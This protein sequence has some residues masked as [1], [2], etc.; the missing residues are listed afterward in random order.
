MQPIGKKITSSPINQ[1]WYFLGDQSRCF[2]FKM[3]IIH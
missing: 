1:S 3:G 2:A